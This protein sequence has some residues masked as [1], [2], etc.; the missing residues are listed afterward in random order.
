MPRLEPVMMMVLS[1]IGHTI[2]PPLFIT[3]QKSEC[4]Q[5]DIEHNIN[6]A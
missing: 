5:S 1:A 3:A 6:R 4:R 2:V